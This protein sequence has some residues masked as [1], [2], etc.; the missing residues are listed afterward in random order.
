MNAPSGGGRTQLIATVAVGMALLTACGQTY[1]ETSATTLAP[2]ATTT[3]IAP[4][5]PA[6]PVGEL[7]DEIETLMLDLD[8]R[9]IAGNQAEA[10]LARIEDLWDAAEP[11]VRALALDTVYQFEQALDLARSGVD[12]KRPAD[13]SKG[14]KLMQ[15]LVDTLPT[16]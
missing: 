6:A 2:D 10:T 13:A 11:Q 3:T 8:E 14:Y 15:Q 4:V 1:L 16:E 12:R 5:D 7:L 9:V